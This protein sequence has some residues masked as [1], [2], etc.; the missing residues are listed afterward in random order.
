MALS[1]DNEKNVNDYYWHMGK[2]ILLI[3]IS[4]VAFIFLLTTLFDSWYSIGAGERG[5]LM[6]MG[7]VYPASF[8]EGFHLKVPYW[9][10][11]AIID[12]KTQ[13]H[14]ID[15]SASSNDLQDV[16]TTLALNYHI[17]PDVAHKVYQEMGKGYKENVIDPTIQEAVK[18]VTAQFTAEEMI[19][20]RPEVA[21]KIEEIL[22]E[23][24]NPRG[25][26]VEQVSIVNFK[27]SEQ[28]TSAIENKVTAEQIRLK[29]VIDLETARLT[30]DQQI[31]KA[32]GEAESIRIRADALKQNPQLVQM[33]MAE[34]WDGKLPTIMMGN[35]GAT[36]LF[37]M[38]GFL[39]QSYTKTA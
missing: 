29:N 18:S 4:I 20:R 21:Q 23:K 14:Q 3:V 11:I 25:I 8:D 19:K 17:E 15:A 9:Q 6:S 24:L 16:V 39:Q 30:R 35:S 1:K 26:I 32:Q 10:Q 2:M 27:F 37:D 38:S 33:T 12:V 7:K 5:V 31:A 22:T 36:P 28:F 34:R 13:K